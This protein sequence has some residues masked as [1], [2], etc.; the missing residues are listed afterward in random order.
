MLSFAAVARNLHCVVSR[1]AIGSS[2]ARAAVCFRPHEMSSPRVVADRRGFSA[3]SA[4][5]AS[6]ESAAVRGAVGARRA[7]RATVVERA[8]DDALCAEQ[9]VCQHFINDVDLA[10]AAA[11]AADNDDDRRTSALRH[12]IELDADHTATPAIAAHTAARQSCRTN[13]AAIA[14][15]HDHRI[16]I[17]DNHRRHWRTKELATKSRSSIAR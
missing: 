10:S 12:A 5:E 7:Q 2:T 14:E 15:Q 9:R 11:A 6:P 8:G 17:F 1:V 3:S 16:N 13:D 4:V